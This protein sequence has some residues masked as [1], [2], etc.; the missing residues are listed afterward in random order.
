MTHTNNYWLIEAKLNI[1]KLQPGLVTFYANW[2]ENRSGLFSSSRGPHGAMDR[3]KP[4][5][6]MYRTKPQF[7]SAAENTWH[8]CLTQRDRWH[9][10][11]SRD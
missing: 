1:M 3:T 4:H 6:A 2:P 11:T 8:M 7:T 9:S 10:Q 5:G